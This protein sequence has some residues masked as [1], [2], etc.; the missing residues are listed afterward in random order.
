MMAIMRHMVNVKRRH[1]FINAIETVFS[2]GEGTF[3]IGGGVGRG[4]LETFG[5]K[6]RGPP[7]SQ[8]RFMHDPS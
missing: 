1:T 5:Q 4:I 8:I 3:L 2:L 6:S 7:T